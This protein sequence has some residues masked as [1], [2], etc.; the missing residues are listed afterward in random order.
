MYY[1][2][3]IIIDSGTEIDGYDDREELGVLLNVP[4][5][6]TNA[7]GSLVGVFIIDRL[8]RRYI[9]LRALPFIFIS[10]ITLVGCMYTIIYNEDPESKHIARIIL[11]IALV[12]YLLFFSLG[13]ST[14]P[15]AVNSEI[16]P[17]HLVGTAVSL[18][19]ATNWLSNFVVAS[20][21]LTSMESDAGKVYTF[22]VLAGFAILAFV[23]IYFLVPE[24]AGKKITENIKNI[25]GEEE[26]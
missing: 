14:A 16:F 9:M 2:P 23:F 18:A 19:T 7:I 6:F 13:F 26:I 21:F 11:M 4:L 17:I 12:A 1:G 8:G 22:A 3:Q 10:L 25:I 24:T 5:A 15:W 20:V